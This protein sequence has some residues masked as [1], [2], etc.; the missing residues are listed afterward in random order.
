MAW[1]TASPEPV[2]AVRS[3]EQYLTYVSAGPFQYAVAEALVLPDTYFE[4]FRAGMRA[5][6]DLLA[7]GL[8]EAGLTVHRPSGTCFVTAGIRPLGERDGIA[9]CRALPERAGVVAVPTAVFH[10][11]HERAPLRPLRLLREA[12]RAGGGGPPAQ[13][14]RGPLSENRLRAVTGPGPARPPARHGR[15]RSRRSCRTARA[16]GQFLLPVPREG[17]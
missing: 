14:R 2:T 13:G 17:Q 11:R 16:G 15:V 1:V 10:D 3:A 4:D 12:V 8:E 9:F 5:K 7:A 6:R